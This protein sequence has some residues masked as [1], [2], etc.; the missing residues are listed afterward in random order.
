LLI[1]NCRGSGPDS[2][3]G[4]PRVFMSHFAFLAG[5]VS[6]QSL[7]L[8]QA[9][10]GAG[11]PVLKR[12]LLPQGELAQ[13]YDAEEPI[14]YMAFVEIRPGCARG[15]HYHKFKRELLYVIQGE[16]SLVVQDIEQGTRDLVPLRMGDVA[17]IGTGVAHAMRAS[18]PGQVIEFS[19][20][21]FDPADTYPF[22]LV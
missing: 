19:P 9:P 8:L 14:R 16:L 22:P 21:R 5:K 13:F 3:A 15:N 12:L 4:A 17:A 18:A 6:K 10:P 1:A 11:A 20:A 2:A 7:P